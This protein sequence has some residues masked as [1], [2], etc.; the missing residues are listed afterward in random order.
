MST[1]LPAGVYVAGQGPAIVLLH[2]SLSSA[3]QWNLLINEL[4]QNYTCISFDLLGYGAAPEVDKPLNH[5]LS[6]ELSRIN[7]VIKDI[8][9]EQPF[10]LVGHSCGGAIALKLAVGNNSK[11]L[12]L[13]LFEPVAF[14]LLNDQPG[15]GGQTD[16][17]AGKLESDDLISATKYFIDFCNGQGAYD[18][19]AISAKSKMHQGMHKVRLDHNALMAEKYTL[20]ELK[21]IQCS[22]LIMLGDRS[23]D[24]I[25]Q[26]GQLIISNLLNVNSKVF[27]AGHMAPLTHAKVVNLAISHHI[28]STGL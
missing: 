17:F 14:H 7:S 2:S 5:N 26:L 1:N 20:A 13:S 22:S 9:G 6:S 10:H 19:L 25:Q 16:I 15:C 23:P 8:I 3:K 11:V 12:S 27:D 18:S 4:Q 21:N 24:L 28:Q